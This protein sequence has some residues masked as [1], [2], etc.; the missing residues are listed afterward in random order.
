MD[1]TE[2]VQDFVERYQL[3]ALVQVA[4]GSDASLSKPNPEL[5]RHA[6]EK[7]EISPD[8][9]LAIGDSTA[10]IEMAHAAKARGCVGVSWGWTQMTHLSQADSLITCFTDIQILCLDP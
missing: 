3:N 10:D 6:C 4:I 7:L 8:Q 9:A 2:N 1:T 5:F